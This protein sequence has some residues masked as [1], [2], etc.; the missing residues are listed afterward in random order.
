MPQHVGVLF[1][2]EDD[3]IVY[4][5]WKQEDTVRETGRM[6]SFGDAGCLRGRCP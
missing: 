5:S 3:D 1:P 2:P 6:L 4:P